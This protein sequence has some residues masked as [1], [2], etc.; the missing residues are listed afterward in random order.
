MLQSVFALC[1]R[2]CMGTIRR[3][4][5]C[6]QLTPRRQKRKDQ[7]ILKPL[8][9]S[10]CCCFSPR[11]SIHSSF[12]STPSSS[13]FQPTSFLLLREN[14]QITA[15]C[16]KRFYV[17]CSG[18]IYI[19]F[20]LFA[21]L[22]SW[23]VMMS[24]GALIPAASIGSASQSVILFL[25]LSVKAAYSYSEYNLQQTKCDFWVVCWS[26]GDIFP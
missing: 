15:L 2:R 21:I 18:S 8:V 6:V 14:S 19:S 10:L 1:G 25:S 20:N 4:R 9:G 17:R 5:V 16:H 24:Q 3:V 22:E 26:V 12:S 13:Q 7:G 23:R 11:L